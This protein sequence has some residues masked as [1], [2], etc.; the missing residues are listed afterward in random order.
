MFLAREKAMFRTLNMMERIDNNFVGYFWA[1]LDEEANIY[2]QVNEFSAVKIQRYNEPNKMAPPTY[3]KT[4]DFTGMFQYLINTYG[5]PRY[6]EANPAL[7]SCV[8][9]PFLFGM[10]YG[11]IGHGSLWLILGIIL[12]MQG[13]NGPAG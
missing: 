10:M 4:N 9:F 6:T 3:I 2:A 5:V 13:A 11:D 7:L 8:T 1:P 12:V